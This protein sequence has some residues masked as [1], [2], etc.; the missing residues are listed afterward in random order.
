V[1]DEFGIVYEYC[2]IY[3]EAFCSGEARGVEAAGALKEIALYSWWEALESL[4]M[5]FQ[6]RFRL[7]GFKSPIF[8]VYEHCSH[9]K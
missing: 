6:G 7:L 2:G 1:A 9:E 8:E 5:R 4:S 3:C